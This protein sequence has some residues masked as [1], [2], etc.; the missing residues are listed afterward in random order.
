MSN[1]LYHF[2]STVTFASPSLYVVVEERIFS[3]GGLLVGLSSPLLGLHM[4]CF[5]Q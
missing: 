1:A 3:F 5:L 4:A 2:P